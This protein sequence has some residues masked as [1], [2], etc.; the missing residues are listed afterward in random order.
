MKVRELVQGL[1]REMRV[2]PRPTTVDTLKA[3]SHEQE[4]RSVA[5]TFMASQ[6]ALQRA[7]ELGAN[8]VITHEPTYFNH[9]DD[10]SWLAGDPVFEAKRRLIEDSGLAIFRIHDSIHDAAPDGILQGMLE[11]LGW[12]EYQSEP[13]SRFVDLPATHPTAR[14][15]ALELKRSLGLA[16]VRVAGNAAATCSRVSC[17]FGACGLRRHQADLAQS[18]VQAVLCGEAQEW[19][20]YEYVRDA[21]T[22]GRDKA[23]IV[24]GHQASEEAGMTYV[25]RVL[26]RIAPSIPVH[27]VATKSSFVDL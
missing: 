9:Q 23:L 22:Q 1:F 10:T 16:S 6:E 7:L 27:F 3:G 4:V 17:L 2:S 13:G 18:D 24:L 8:L 15:L 14:E 5:V 12:L 19:E 11:R 20:S 26:S 21:A 25:T